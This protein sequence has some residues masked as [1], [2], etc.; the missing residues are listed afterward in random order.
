MQNIHTLNARDN[1]VL[2]WVAS[3]FPED[4]E[5]FRQ[6]IQ[7]ELATVTKLLSSRRVKYSEL[8]SSL[9]PTDKGLQVVFLYDW[10]DYTSSNYAV[11]FA[12]HW[13]PLIRRTLRTSSKRGDLLFTDRPDALLDA[14]VR[15]ANGKQV[16][17]STQYAVYFSNL[18]QSDV[19]LL[20][21]S[22]SAVPRYGGYIDVTLAGPVRNYIA[23][24]LTFGT[25]FHDGRVILSH[26]ADEPYV[27]D[28]DP[29]RF[30]YKENGIEVVSFIDMFFYGFLD[31]KIESDDSSEFRVDVSLCLA[32]VTG[33]FINVNEA[34]VYVDPRK[35]EK[36]LLFEEPKLRLMTSIGLGAVTQHE[37]E[38]LVRERLQENYVYDLQTAVDGTPKFAVSAEFEKP[39]GTTTRRLLALKYDASEK[40]IALVSMY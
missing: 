4:P 35:I 37:L 2:P 9:V 5:G 15:R 32:A 27:S 23:S 33:E 3:I 6:E 14:S 22:L 17:W 7:S 40:R 38:V 20:H 1:A 10:E 29:M 26:G 12:T 19:D 8:K 11:E 25:I 16:K 36:Y 13:L 31:Y 39:D 18:S 34:A 28:E 30:P 21:S 24:C